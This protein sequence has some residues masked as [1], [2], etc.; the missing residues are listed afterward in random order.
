MV[1]LFDRLKLKIN[2]YIIIDNFFPE[3]IC[4]QLRSYA[5]NDPIVNGDDWKT[6]ISKTFDFDYSH[7]S[8]KFIADNY[9]A[10]KVSF[11]KKDSYNRSWSNVYENFTG[12]VAPHIDPGSYFTVNI[13]VTSDDAILDKSKNGLKVYKKKYNKMNH[14]G[15]VEEEFIKTTSYDI[16]PYRYNRAVVF[17]GNT[18]HETNEVSMKS[19]DENKRIN[20]TFLYNK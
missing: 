5:L 11:L 6:H 20:Y 14:G 9:V 3:K 16:I 13:W 7:S 8:L 18:V 10:S 1:W 12:G 2:N 15:V 19:G 17:R 4:K